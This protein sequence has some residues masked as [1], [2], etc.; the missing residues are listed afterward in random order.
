MFRSLLSVLLVSSIISACGSQSDEVSV[1]H[2]ANTRL[3]L[4]SDDVVG[5]AV[6]PGVISKNQYGF[7][8]GGGAPVNEITFTFPTCSD[9]ATVEVS[10]Y[11]IDRNEQVQVLV[12]GDEV[13]LLSRGR[14]NNKLNNGDSFQVAANASPNTLTFK[15]IENNETWGVTNIL[16]RNCTAP[17]TQQSDESETTPEV[18]EEFVL[19]NDTV[20]TDRYGQNYGSAGTHSEALF[21]F[22][23]TGESLLLAV[24]GYDINRDNEVS[25]SLNGQILGYLSRGRKRKLNGGDTF[26]ISA[27]SQLASSNVVTFRQQYTGETWGITNLSVMRSDSEVNQPDSGEPASPV[28][29]EPIA[30]EP[31]TGASN[32][33]SAQPGPV[34]P[35]RFTSDEG[36]YGYQY[37]PSSHQQSASFSFSK[38]Q[39]DVYLSVYGFDIDTKKEIQVEL[40]GELIGHLTR[41]P[42]QAETEGDVFLLPVLDQ[43]PGENVVTF[44]QRK[45]GEP[46][47]VTKLQLL[48]C[49]YSV[50]GTTESSGAPLVISRETGTVIFS[51]FFNGSAITDGTDRYVSVCVS[52]EDE[53]GNKFAHF[54]TDVGQDDNTA[55]KAYP[56]FIIGSKFGLTSETSFRPYPSLVSST[57]FEYPALD[58]VSSIVG[59]PAFTYNLDHTDID[60]IVDID[61]QNVAG[62]IRDVMLESWF[63]DTSAGTTDAGN[64]TVNSSDWRPYQTLPP[65]EGDGAQFWSGE[66]LVGTLN[67]FVGAGHP[68]GTAESRNILLEMMV[69]VG[70]LSPND[71]SGSSRNPSRYRLT[72]TPVTIGDYQYHIWFSSTYIAP[73]VVYSRE[74]NALGQPLLDLTDEGEI[75]L[76]WNLFLDYSL[77]SL[78][79]QLKALSDKAQLGQIEGKSADYQAILAAALAWARRDSDEYVFDKM[80]ANSGAIS[81]IEF[82]IEPQT[83]NANDEPYRATVRKFEVLIRGK[84][85]GL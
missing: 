80:R 41:G 45:G 31:D 61:E 77:H 67:N 11:D 76:D 35:L 14:G 9:Q 71:V 85:F 63:Y 6:T 8:Y 32:P 62:S 36:E 79:P 18:V 33:E 22:S 44:R 60:V 2:N 26:T 75:N 53:Q 59:L 38:F 43:V 68:N 64:H 24:S 13:G 12:N 56:E 47:G 34:I 46:W 4:I 58:V 16:V 51:N 30:I 19:L 55:I 48:G 27:S 66:P 15:Q 28:I 3:G 21:T 84:N 25:V 72:D 81:G 29:V 50:N 39:S 49:A 42:N 17:I 1:T 37:G 57:G 23:N 82:G 52:A 40:N 54:T 69:H 83:N 73:L 10:G 20:N 65:V 74:T 7:N 5:I 70:P 78:E